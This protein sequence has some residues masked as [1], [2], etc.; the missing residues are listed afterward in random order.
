MVLLELRCWQQERTELDRL[1]RLLQDGRQARETDAG[2]GPWFQDGNL[3][4]RAEGAGGKKQVW[5]RSW[6]SRSRSLERPG[7]GRKL[8]SAPCPK[9]LEPGKG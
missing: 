4:G 1:E 8:F 5:A 3:S 2:P 9:A 6:G 7:L